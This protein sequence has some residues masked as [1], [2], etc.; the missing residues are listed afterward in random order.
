MVFRRFS[1]ELW[2]NRLPIFKAF[3][4]NF[5][6]FAK[7]VSF[8]FLKTF[9]WISLPAG[10]QLHHDPV[11]IS[12]RFLWFS[13]GFLM[14][15]ER[16]A[17]QFSKHSSRISSTLPKRFPAVFQ[18]LSIEFRFQQDC[19]FTRI[20]LR[21]Q[22]VSYGF[23]K[24]FLWIVRES[25]ANFQSIPPEF[26][27]LCQRGFLQFSKDFQLNF[28]SSRIATSPGSCWDFNSFPMVFLRFSYE[29]WRNRLPSFEAFLKNFNHYAKEVSF[30]FLK[31]L[32]GISLPTARRS[33][34]DSNSFLMVFLWF[35]HE[36]WR[37]RLPTFKAFLMNLN[38]YAKEVSFSFLKTLNWISLPAGV[39]LHH[40]PVEI[41]IRFLWFS[42]VLLMNCEWIACKFKKH[43]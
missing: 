7:E 33:C 19:N 39:Q 2:K 29:L 38:H 31:T 32:N 35:C 12:I 14:N 28:A 5:Q 3:L 17:C 37:N 20:L 8:S 1:Y 41:S 26:P 27:T 9:N 10:L 24:V 22:F 6:H 4:K 15:C 42:L 13:E 16:I 25:L 30:S 18:R 36:L 43:S 34:W 11:E 21:F 23:P 40:D